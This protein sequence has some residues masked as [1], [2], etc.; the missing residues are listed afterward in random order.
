M[1]KNLFKVLLSVQMLA[2]SVAA[3]AENEWAIAVVEKGQDRPVVLEYHGER[4]T[5]SSGIEYLRIYDDSYRF[6]KEPYNPIKSKYG[7]R[8]DNKKIYIYDFNL[9][10]IVADVLKESLAFDFTLSAGEKFTTI[11]GVEWVVESVKDT[12]VNVSVKGKGDAISKKLL[13]VRSADGKYTDKWLEDFGSFSNHFMIRSMENI[14]YSQTL[15]MEYGYGEYLA[16]EFSDDPLFG[17]D[18]GWMEIEPNAEVCSHTE[19]YSD[20][21]LAVEDVR[22]EYEHR[23]YRCFYREGDFIRTL[24]SWELKPHVDYDDRFLS[25]DVFVFH[26]LPEPANRYEIELYAVLPTGINSASSENMRAAMYDLQGRRLNSHPTKGLYLCDG[27]KRYV[28]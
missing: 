27:K 1:N 26:G 14:A 8:M 16:R 23:M 25:K 2:S 11:N 17:H 21:S 9:D 18:T 6:R 13:N 10:N 5:A 7:Y 12:L 19:T 4:E 15:F 24:C 22:H 20:G 28:K 3:K